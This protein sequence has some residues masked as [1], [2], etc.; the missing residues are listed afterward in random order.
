MKIK[1]KGQN[2]IEQYPILSSAIEVS[3]RRQWERLL[4]G[5]FVSLFFLLPMFIFGQA[6][7]LFSV[8]HLYK[9]FVTTDF[10]NWI[11]GG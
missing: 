10:Y 5:T 1:G 4:G 6:F 2:G 7:I 11:I 8:G 9:W 3:F